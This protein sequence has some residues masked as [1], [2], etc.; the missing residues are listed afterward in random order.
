MAD[1]KSKLNA[2]IGQSRDPKTGR[3]YTNAQIA[4]EVGVSE[5]LIGQLRSGVRANPTW[6]TID[7]L[8]KFFKVPVGYF[9]DEQPEQPSTVDPRVQEALRNAGVVH[10]ATRAAELSEDGLRTVMD[11]IDAVLAREQLDRQ[12]RPNG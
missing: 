2:L 1:F 7:A 9:F 10:I 3:P 12:S 6:Q 4:R 5:S 11:V 8:A